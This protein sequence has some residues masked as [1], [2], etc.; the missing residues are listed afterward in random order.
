MDRS[1]LELALKELVGTEGVN[2]SAVVTRDGIMVEFLN[3][4]TP[5]EG[6][7]T[8]ASGGSDDAEDSGEMHENA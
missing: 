7:I 8:T 5:E 1:E 2:A 3:K 4:H 6:G